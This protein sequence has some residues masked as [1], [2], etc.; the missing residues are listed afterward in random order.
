[1]IIKEFL[2]NPVGNDQGGEYIK[3]YNNGPE[4]VLLN[5]W[6]LKDAS[7]K[8]YNL[9]GSLPAGQELVLS[10][11]QT[12]ILLNN[13]GEKIFL[14]DSTGKLVDELGYSGQASKG[15]MIIKE[16][17]LITGE[18]ENSR[19]DTEKLVTGKIGIDTLSSTI[20]FTGFLTAV[21]LAILG[22][23]L[24]LQIEKKLEIKLW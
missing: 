16:Q 1:M 22:L 5:G 15:Q 23:Y 20:L 10:Q 3:L 21:I 18:L 2:P 17:K 4:A 9:R 11:S 14:Y 8:A 7:G 24:I 6:I 19:Q 13:N 12:K